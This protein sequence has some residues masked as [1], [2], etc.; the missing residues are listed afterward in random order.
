MCLAVSTDQGETFVKPNLHLYSYNG[1]TANNIVTG[2][3]SDSAGVSVFADPSAAPAQRFK[4]IVGSYVYA[5]ADGLNFTQLY[6]PCIHHADDTKNTAYFDTRLGKYVIFVRRDLQVPGKSAGVVRWI[7]RCV[8]DDL[9]NWE[10]EAPDGCPTV[11]GPDSVD[12]DL[13]DVYTNSL[14]ILHDNTYVFFPSF[15]HHFGHNPFGFGNDGLL[16]IRLVVSRNA[17]SGPLSYVPGAANA[18]S[19][20]VPLT[21][22]L[23]GPYKAQV[24][25]RVGGGGCGVRGEGAGGGST[26]HIRHGLTGSPLPKPSS[27]SGWCAPSGSDLAATT[28]GTSA[29]YMASGHLVSADK[30]SLYFYASAQP[31]TH[32]GDAASK[33]WGAN[34]GIR[35]V[36]YE[37][38]RLA[39]VVFPYAFG[40]PQNQSLVTKPLTVPPAT[41]CP[42]PQ[43]N[44]T[45]HTSC[46]FEQPTGECAGA[47]HPVPCTSNADCVL[48]PCTAGG[49]DRCTCHDKP[50]V[51]AADRFC[52]ASDGDRGSRLCVANTTTTT[53]GV[54]AMINV[55]T[56]VVG[57]VQAEV[58]GGGDAYAL[59]AAVPVKGNTLSAAL[60]WTGVGSSLNVFA[61]KEI[62]LRLA[63]ADANLYSLFF[64]CG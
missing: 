39:A 11:F 28:A 17:S 38:D 45:L 33:T 42:P 8:T 49:K 23:C 37:A 7:G 21:L 64:S 40:S 59:A 3:P 6:G 14:S 48:A 9:S 47:F 29:T 24:R 2:G 20:V 41:S 60:E 16:D 51:C 61:G 30:R 18:R 54:T 13:V 43:T 36:T 1:S 19:P 46:A 52:A 57:F 53:G 26:P 4:M 10:K 50:V 15:Y 58:V 35:R 31:M 32:G 63:G 25:K 56:S 44:T 55:R 27:P 62:Q 34:T 5:G 12:P 22:N